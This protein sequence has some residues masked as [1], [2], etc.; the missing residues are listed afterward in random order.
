MKITAFLITRMDNPERFKEN[1]ELYVFSR[2]RYERTVEDLK[3]LGAVQALV[4][5]ASFSH[6][7]ACSIS[8]RK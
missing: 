3:A 7:L 8:Y 2:T 1:V 4:C 5:D 6:H